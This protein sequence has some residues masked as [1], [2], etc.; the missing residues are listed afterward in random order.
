MRKT[1]LAASI[2]ALILPSVATSG[3][4]EELLQ[5]Q[6][7]TLNL[8]EALVKEG[9]LSQ[10]AAD[11]LIA[12]ARKQAA[13]ETQAAAARAAS[14]DNPP[15]DDGKSVRVTYVPQFVRDEI[16]DQVRAELREDVAQDVL[17]QAKNEQWGVPGVLP[18]WTN[19]ITIKG[20]IRLRDQQEMY[21][22]GNAPQCDWQAS[23]DDDSLCTLMNTS[24]DRNKLR[25]RLRVSVDAK[26]TEGIK[27]GIRITT[28]NTDN[29]VS[30]NQTLGN[31]G[32]RYDLVLDQAYLRYDALNTERYRWLRLWGG[33][34]PNPFLS[35]TDLVWD[36]DLG[37]EGVAGTLRMNVPSGEGLYADEASDRHL[38][39][40]LGAFPLAT[41][42]SVAGID[43]D[44]WL[45]GAQAGADWG[46]ADQSRLELGLAYFDYRD[47]EGRLDPLGVGTTAWTAPDYMQKG[48]SVFDLNGDGSSPYG[49]LSDFD[50]VNF[51]A[52]YDITRFAPTHVILSADYARNLGFDEDEILQRTGLDAEPEVDAWQVGVTVGWP[53]IAKRRD[54]QVFTFYKHLERDAVLDAFTDSDFHL[55]GT[56]AEGWILGGSYG[57]ADNTWLTLKYMTADEIHGLYDD[58]VP[59]G[60]PLGIDVVQ[61]DVN[62]RF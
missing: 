59:D 56:N 62:A 44:K 21:A 22:D 30:T 33:R 14:E 1:L 2:C 53:E 51:T 40:T 23:N 27:A 18:D 37:F 5:V 16:R 25:A 3:E 54:W 47:I 13:D 36:S 50:I 19:R 35:T 4:R 9:V 38:F 7:T 11:R 32:N 45:Y 49:L 39:L 58:S 17:A 20:D 8:I 55:G 46:F 41:A 26:V 28:G 43:E 48:N 6:A 31:Y 34:M 61:M 15:P 12:D 42:S 29:P 24:E 57:L 52:R 60:A 10:A